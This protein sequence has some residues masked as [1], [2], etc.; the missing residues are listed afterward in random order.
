MH[1]SQEF[2]EMLCIPFLKIA[3]LLQSYLYEVEF[4]LLVSK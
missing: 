2:V 3:A 1:N 4:E